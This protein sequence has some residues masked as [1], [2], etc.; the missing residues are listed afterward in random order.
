V[1]LAY[2]Q[3][4]ADVGGEET[5]L[6]DLLAD[7]GR[8]PAAEME[9]RELKAYLR[10]AVVHLPERQ[11]LVVV[12]Y[13]V[14]ERTSEELARFLGV[15]ESRVS[16]IRSEAL[17]NL[18]RGIEAQYED[19]EP[20]SDHGDDAGEGSLVDRRRAAYA[21][22]IRDACTLGERVSAPRAGDRT[23]DLRDEIERLVA[24]GRG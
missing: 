20:R 12:G 2:E 3:V 23:E 7:G 15:T 10:Q 9:D 22:R 24:A 6:V 5:A 14:E 4:G 13:F 1:V 21:A 16:Q 17:A 19:P 11:R 18:R 8:E